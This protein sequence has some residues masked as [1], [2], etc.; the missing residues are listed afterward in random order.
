MARM[1]RSLTGLVNWPSTSTEH[2]HDIIS[3]QDIYRPERKACN[4]LAICIDLPSYG[5]KLAKAARASARLSARQLIASSTDI[6]SLH[7]DSA[8]DMTVDA[9][10]LFEDA[11]TAGLA[12]ATVPVNRARLG[13]ARANM[14]PELN[15]QLRVPHTSMS[16]FVEKNARDLRADPGRVGPGRGDVE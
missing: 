9:S 6:V 14:L 5:R 16:S 10:L 1:C 11:V 7:Y 8:A 3:L 2:Q 15:R 12:A 4:W 13:R